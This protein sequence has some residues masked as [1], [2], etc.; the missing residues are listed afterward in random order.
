MPNLA[1][2]VIN[3]GT[4]DHTFTPEGA[5]N[6]VFTF[7]KV[8]SSGIYAHRS[9]LTVSATTQSDHRKV[10]VKLRIPQLVTNADTGVTT[11]AGYDEFKHEFRPMLES[12]GAERTVMAKLGQALLSP[13]NEAIAP[14]LIDMENYY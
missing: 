10:I 5:V 4:A 12:S 6:G 9:I 7:V 1:P 3:D 2:I 11:V 8:P 13:T 14:V